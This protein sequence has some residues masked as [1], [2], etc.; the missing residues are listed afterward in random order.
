MQTCLI[1]AF[2]SML[3]FGLSPLFYK[4]GTNRGINPFAVNWM[5]SI[6]AV[7]LTLTLLPFFTFFLSQCLRMDPSIL[8]TR[9]EPFLGN[10]IYMTSLKYIDLSYASPLTSTYPLFIIIFSIIFSSP[11]PWILE[12]TGSLLAISGIFVSQL[13]YSPHLNAKV[14]GIGC[15]GYYN[16]FT[17]ILA[18][19]RRESFTLWFIVYKITI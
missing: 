8:I 15:F 4:Y 18:V 6:G 11:I 19:S 13:T 5:I 9:G 17:P 1:F 14:Q 16:H 3:S 12:I 10:T 2:L 7:F